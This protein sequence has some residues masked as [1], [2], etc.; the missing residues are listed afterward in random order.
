VTANGGVGPNSDVANTGAAVLIADIAD[1]RSTLAGLNLPKTVQVGNSEAGSYF[2]TLVLQ[3]SDY[4]VRALHFRRQHKISGTDGGVA[5]ADE[6][7]TP[8]VCEH[9]DRGRRV[10]DGGL[11][12]D[13]ERPTRGV[14]EQQADHVDRRNRLADCAC[15][16]R[17]LSPPQ[18]RRWRTL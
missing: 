5:V 11:L 18:S 9:D 6:Q 17:R 1:M 2:N 3:Q 7:C 4:G 13:H 8:V 16:S 10:L 12:R 15:P 14:V